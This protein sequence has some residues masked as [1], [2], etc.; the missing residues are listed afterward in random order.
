VDWLSRRAGS[1]IR[2]AALH[3]VVLAAVLGGSVIALL[4]TTANGVH[5]VAI[6]QLDAE[7]QSFQDAV[8]ARPSGLS[9]HDE[10]THYLT[11][12][13]VPDGNL[14]EVSVPD[15]WTVVNARAAQLASSATIASDV[16]TV[17]HATAVSQDHVDG[18]DLEVLVAPIRSAD[19]PSGVFVAAVDLTAL[20]PA[21]AATERIA[22]GEA[23]IALVAGVASAY[24]LLRRLLRRVG[25]IT[26]TAERIGRGR[27]AER[28]G[29]QGTSDEVGRLA[30]SFDSMLDSIESAVNAQ[31]ELLSDV[32]HQLRTPLTVARGHLEV[33]GRAGV[34][35]PSEVRATI[36]V[37]I[38]E[39]DRMGDLVERLLV[40]GRAR[41]PVRRDIHD[42]DLRAFFSDLF[43]SCQVIA[44][45]HWV[46]DPVPDAVVSFDET[47]VRGAV[48]NLIDN[49]VKATGSGE[50][51]AI[52]TALTA[53]HLTISVED[54]GRGIPETHREAVLNRF[55]RPGGSSGA[56]TGLG[57]AIV[58]AVAHAHGGAVTVSTSRYGGAKVTMTLERGPGR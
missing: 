11:V 27:L 31:H 55:V 2:L 5:A 40:L 15:Q 46:L 8:N 32:S 13:A 21:G 29:D 18:R 22:I 45:R 33:L 54:S 28:L 56:G 57:L 39:L 12:H 53:T 30:T 36:D 37:A 6:G 26:D 51:V 44:D 50:A 10:A 42:V 23:T 58:S 7:V 19:E 52:S 49:S 24:L 3:A 34:E 43:R 4:R 16:R 9:L 1:A 14:I 48:L 41:E 17:P 38:G 47:E 25:S 20:K 35:D